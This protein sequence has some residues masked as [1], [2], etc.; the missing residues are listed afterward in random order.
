[1]YIEV[2]EKT[3]YFGPVKAIELNSRLTRIK[4][5]LRLHAAAGLISPKIN[6]LKLPVTIVSA[7]RFEANIT[8]KTI[9]KR[10]LIFS[11]AILVVAGL[12]K[13]ALNEKVRN[14]NSVLYDQTTLVIFLRFVSIS[15][16]VTYKAGRDVINP[17]IRHRKKRRAS[18]EK[19][20][21]NNRPE[22]VVYSVELFL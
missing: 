6:K 14:I 7:I 16:R 2:S 8:P 20:R 15:L 11:R 18:V 4:D 12:N 13:T 10:G 17:L 3:K 21:G 5:Q 19:K 22:P 1:M 9:D